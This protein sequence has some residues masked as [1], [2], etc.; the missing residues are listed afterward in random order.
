MF[1]DAEKTEY[2]QIKAPKHLKHRI[3]RTLAKPRFEF[4]CLM[5]L[6]ACIALV[7]VISVF[8]FQQF[9]PKTV[10]LSYLGDTVTEQGVSVSNEVESAA[11]FGA[12]TIV[13]SGIPLYVQAV[14]DTKISVSGGS[15]YVFDGKDELLQVGTNLTLDATSKIQ[16]DVSDLP[17]GD[18][19]LTLATQIYTVRIDAENGELTI[20]KK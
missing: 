2:A 12:K 10:S 14:K 7:T 16:W 5:T 8:S 20:F 17:T 1:N 9:V 19:T 4:K 13:P 18:Y 6:A 3:E 15:I 11:A